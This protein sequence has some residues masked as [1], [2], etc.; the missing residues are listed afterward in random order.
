MKY[1][2]FKKILTKIVD[3]EV[4]DIDAIKELFRLINY[5]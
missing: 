2:A 1:V 4:D 5:D 3:T